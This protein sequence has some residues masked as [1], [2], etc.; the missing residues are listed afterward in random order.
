M[1]SERRVKHQR[2]RQAVLGGFIFLATCKSHAALGATPAPTDEAASEVTVTATRVPEPV[3]Q[4]PVSISVV[5]GG[6][7]RARDA[8]EMASALSGVSGVEAPAGG[9]AGPSRDRKSTRLNSSHT[10]ISYAVF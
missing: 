4:I 9:D 2:F 7:L 6:E 5:S 3:D 1:K 8:W 10:V